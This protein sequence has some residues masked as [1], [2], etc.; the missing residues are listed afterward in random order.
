MW[1]WGA[2]G[3]KVPQRSLKESE[4]SAWRRPLLRPVVRA[5]LPPPHRAQGLGVK[6]TAA[7]LPQQTHPRNTG[8]VAEPPVEDLYLPRQRK[9]PSVAELMETTKRN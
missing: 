2:T 8:V 3:V 4:H 1:G 9:S 5:L 6:N 7:D